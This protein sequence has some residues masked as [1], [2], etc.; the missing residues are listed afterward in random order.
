MQENIN[1]SGKNNPMYGKLRI[2]STETKAK[3]SVT[4]G[5]ATFVYDPNGLLVNTF[6][7]ARK[8]AKHFGSNHQIILRLVKNNKLFQDKCKLSIK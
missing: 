5:T 8:A 6:N 2:H 1:K 3:I 7:S 4:Q